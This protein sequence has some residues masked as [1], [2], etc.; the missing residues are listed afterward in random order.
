MKDQKEKEPDLRKPK[1]DEKPRGAGLSRDA[2]HALR[3]II[4]GL[5]GYSEI[6]MATPEL[7]MQVYNDIHMVYE[8]GLD[9]METIRQ[10]SKSPTRTAHEYEV[11]NIDEL[12]RNIADSACNESERAIDIVLDSEDESYYARLDLASFRWS[13]L[14]FILYLSQLY[15]EESEIS[16]G[17]KAIE[18]DVS[19]Y[20]GPDEPPPTKWIEIRITIPVIC[21]ITNDELP[22]EML[23]AA[24]DR[25]L[26]VVK[27]L[28]IGSYLSIR[29]HGGHAFRLGTKDAVTG[30][31]VLIPQ[32][33]QDMNEP[34]VE[35]S[36]NI[37]TTD[38]VTT[39]VDISASKD[40]PA[41]V[42]K[43]LVIDDDKVVL[44][45]VVGMLEQIGF[46]SIGATTVDSAIYQFEKEHEH[47]PLVISDVVM[48]KMHGV[49]LVRILKE[50][51]P[52]V[53]IVLMT[54]YFSDVP[55]D[56]LHDI[57]ISGWIEKP[58]NMTRL[59]HTVEQALEMR[60]NDVSE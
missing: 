49:E 44:D 14:S 42:P 41:G 22:L 30:F 5:V 57:D 50:I 29:R 17:L 13:I 37:E 23:V 24:R 18:I 45:V 15:P 28:L 32:A 27:P 8:L 35:E 47:I 60:L 48:P 36:L 26:D 38:E 10:P 43:I 12:M 54:G 16:I 21:D 7:P 25:F 39:Q 20:E 11:Q 19:T 53:R 1:I 4:Q 31:A 55:D 46:R 3:N 34:V 9:A 51:D 6:L 2:L 52:H 56:E 33:E 58:M 40:S 59:Q